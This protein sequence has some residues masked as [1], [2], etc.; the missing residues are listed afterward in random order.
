MDQLWSDRIRRLH[1]TPRQRE[2][3]KVFSQV[4]INP[5]GLEKKQILGEQFEP[6]NTM[7]TLIFHF[8]KIEFGL[9]RYHIRKT[10]QRCQIKFTVLSENSFEILV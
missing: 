4:E 1:Q 2:E 7:V 3:E 5:G 8:Y 9:Y 6:R 10:Q